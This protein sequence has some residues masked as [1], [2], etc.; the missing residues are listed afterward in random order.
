M[1]IS[2]LLLASLLVAVS[3]CAY[4]VV[5]ML[6]MPAH[7]RWELYPIPKGPPGRRSYGGSYYEESDWWT[8]QAD[9]GHAGEFL[10]MLKE[11]FLLRG[12][13]ESFRELWTWSLLLHWGLYGC[14]ASVA[15]AVAIAA[16]HRWLTLDTAFILFAAVTLIYTTACVVGAV[17]AA[18]LIVMR[19]LHRRVVAF[20][21]RTAI[22]NLVLLGCIFATGALS[23]FQGSFGAMAVVYDAVHS[24]FGATSMSGITYLHVGLVAFFLVYFPFTHMTH[25][26]MKYFTWH[27]VRWDDEA[28]V[29]SRSYE[30]ACTTNLSQKPTWSAAHIGASAD[31]NWADVATTTTPTEV[32]RA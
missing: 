2:A 11:V 22:F 25:M 4:R 29:R 16:F 19:S 15:S 10:F 24:P 9:S 5:R 1:T 31:R 21:T 27:K 13:W 3:G 8:K 7:L 14:L 6:R 17:G 18:G 30:R 26:F 23:V 20:T 32:R 12:V 28:S